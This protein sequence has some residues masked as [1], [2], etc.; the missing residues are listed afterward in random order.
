M[1]ELQINTFAHKIKLDNFIPSS[2]A[3]TSILHLFDALESHD[4]IHRVVV[5]I[6]E[7]DCQLTA[8]IDNPELYESF[9]TL[10]HDFYGVLKD[11]PQI[12]FLG[13]TGVTRLKDVSIFSVG[14]D[15]VDVS[16]F[17][18][19]ASITGFTREEIKKYYIDYLNLGVSIEKDKSIDE[20]TI[21]EREELLDKISEQ[22]NGYCF[23]EFNEIKVFSTYSV[24]NFFSKLLDV[25]KLVYGDYWYDVGGVSTILARYLET[26]EIDVLDYENDVKVDENSFLNPTSLIDINQRVLMTQT[27]YLTLKSKLEN[28]D[29]FISLGIPNSEIKRALVKTTC[30]KI[31]G[32]MPSIKS[33]SRHNVEFGS[34]E[35]I[36]DLFTAIL[37]LVPY[38]YRLIRDEWSL[39][40]AYLI[41]FKMANFPI[42]PENTTLKGRSD[43]ELEFNQRRIVI[44]FKFAKDE[45]ETKKQLNNAINQINLRDYVN[46]PPLKELIRIALVYDAQNREI[47]YFEKV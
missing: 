28:E 9:R 10:I 32:F 20:V 30:I 42:K 26:H 35:E 41:A 3:K 8:N 5:L 12:R 27:G 38:E 36:K 33:T 21:D 45:S 6:D 44:E 31:I 15:I 23:D 40:W 7:Y 19:I 14:S 18:N 17:H 47:A 11:I 43:I 24:N 39:C 25:K 46:I 22:Y 34:F 29:R 2:H 1:R 4:S 16:Y 13:I 37:N